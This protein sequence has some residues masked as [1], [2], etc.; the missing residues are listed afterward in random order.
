M[1]QQV[2]VLPAGVTQRQQQAV[3]ANIVLDQ[4]D[5][6]KVLIVSGT[7]GLTCSLPS[8]SAVAAGFYCT[9]IMASNHSHSV[10]RVDAVADT[11]T[12]FLEGEGIPL[13]VGLNSG[14]VLMGGESDLGTSNGARLEVYC[15]GELWWLFLPAWGVSS[16]LGGAGP[17]IIF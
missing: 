14:I 1:V 5:T 11:V 6:G 12:G 17:P 3:N 7:T 13:E 2:N 8:A 15:D 10:Q 16:A 9:V 4:F